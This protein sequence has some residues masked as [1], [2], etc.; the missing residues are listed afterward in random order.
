MIWNMN[1]F[2]SVY[3]YFAALFHTS[4]KRLWIDIMLIGFINGM[5]HFLSCCRIAVIQIHFTI[6]DFGKT[7]LYSSNS[8]NNSYYDYYY[9][10]YCY[11]EQ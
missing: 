2:K 5:T 8:N 4:A 9:Y 11:Y 1:Y 6:F 7:F 10:Y 3:N